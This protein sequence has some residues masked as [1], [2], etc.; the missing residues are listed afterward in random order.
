VICATLPSFKLVV[1][2]QLP[3]ASCQLPVAG[4]WF[5][6]FGLWSLVF[7]LWFLVFCFLPSVVSIDFFPD[8]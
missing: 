6:V 5:L 8:H 4:F 7:G 1:S 3:V 2:Y